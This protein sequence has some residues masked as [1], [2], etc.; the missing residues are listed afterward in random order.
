MDARRH[1]D[2]PHPLANLTVI[3]LADDPGGEFSGQLLAEMGA[4]VIKVEPPQGSPSRAI[5]PFARDQAGPDASLNFWYYNANK[6]SV[7]L[8]LEGADGV[9]APLFALL[10]RA[11]IF[12][13][14]PAAQGPEG[15]WPG[16]RGLSRIHI[17]A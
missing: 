2:L 9:A 1:T 8:D 15:A 16:P 7:T 6:L 10:A 11:D 13:L 17:P 14:H 5:G 12:Y 4:R 3:E